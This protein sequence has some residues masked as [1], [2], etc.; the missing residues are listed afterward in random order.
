LTVVNTSVKIMS[1][2]K[3]DSTLISFRVP[4]NVHKW[5]T[6]QAIDGESPSKTVQR[7]VK[8]LFES[9]GTEL[10]PELLTD[11]VDTVNKIVDEQLQPL[12]EQIAALK[13]E[14]KAEL[15]EEL[16]GEYAA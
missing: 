4:A 13:A 8:D 11:G 12:R 5:I 10:S 6:D 3:P 7:W 1:E 15:K 14:V 2:S 16:L 9:K